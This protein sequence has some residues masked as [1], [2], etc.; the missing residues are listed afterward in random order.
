MLW[1][2]YFFTSNLIVKQFI[3]SKKFLRLRKGV[4]IFIIGCLKNND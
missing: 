1:V 2:R 4:L 3:M